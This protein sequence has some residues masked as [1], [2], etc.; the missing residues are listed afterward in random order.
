MKNRDFVE[1]YFHALETP[2]LLLDAQGKVCFANAEAVQLLGTAD[3][4]QLPQPWCWAMPTRQTQ[5]LWASDDSGRLIHWRITPLADGEAL[6]FGDPMAWLSLHPLHTQLLSVFTHDFNNLATILMGNLRLLEGDESLS[7]DAKEILADSLGASQDMLALTQRFNS[8]LRDDRRAAITVDVNLWWQE[9]SAWWV[10]IAGGSHALSAACQPFPQPLR[11]KLPMFCQWFFEVLH[12]AQQRQA[13]PPLRLL[14]MATPTGDL[15]LQLSPLLLTESDLVVFAHLMQPWEGQ[16]QRQGETLTLSFAYETAASIAPPASRRAAGQEKPTV[17]VVED[18][19]N[20]RRLLVRSV[21]HLGYATVEA[22]DAQAAQDLIRTYNPDLVLSD[23]RMPG[24]I[25]GRGL[26]EWL[27]VHYPH[28]P[29]ILATGYSS[30]LELEP[31]LVLHKPFSLD[32]LAKA[33]RQQ[34]Q[35]S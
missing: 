12:Q 35:T 31:F 6:A 17:L 5:S 1:K 33:L 26:A 25:D 27:Q 22:A 15:A 10:Q 32:A 14:L 28:I 3:L 7:K 4:T 2:L 8:L 16:V 29:V 11:L 18:E 13:S 34:L 19:G 21:R 30:E 9:T 24:A 20:V 23:V